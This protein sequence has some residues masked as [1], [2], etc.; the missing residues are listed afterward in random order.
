MRNLRIESLNGKEIENRKRE[1][2]RLRI[3]VFREFPY[4]YDGDFKYEENY[5]E[6][7]INS[8]ES[9]AVLVFDGDDAVGVS[10]ALPMEHEEGD[11][12]RPFTED[13][14]DP[15]RVFYCGESVLLKEYR[16][17]GLYSDFFSRR[18]EHAKGLGR[19][20]L[21]T[22]CAVVRDEGHPLRPAQY[23]PLD[24][25]WKRYGYTRKPE[26]RTTYKWKDLG[27]NSESKKEMVFWIK[28]I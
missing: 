25:I 4:L 28:E 23:K 21:C 14:Y 11:F 9:L 13:G 3:T 18:E 26:L 16:G 7:Y 15:S 10:T 8:P 5:L 20:N 24:S 17:R 27:E 6:T 12:M 19:F 2:A 1:I 22:F